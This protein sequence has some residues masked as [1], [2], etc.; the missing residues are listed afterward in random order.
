MCFISF[1]RVYHK[2]WQAF[3]TFFF[4]GYVQVDVWPMGLL[5]TGDRQTSRV[6][7]KQA[8]VNEGSDDVD[9]RKTLGLL[10]DYLRCLRL[11]WGKGKQTFVDFWEKKLQMKSLN[12]EGK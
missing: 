9:S 4:S 1:S 7:S 6:H 3:G 10:N 5:E 2:E 11:D 12:E 8:T